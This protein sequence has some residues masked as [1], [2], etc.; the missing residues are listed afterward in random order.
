MNCVVSDSILTGLVQPVLGSFSIN[1]NELALKTQLRLDKKLKKIAEAFMKG[2][3][4]NQ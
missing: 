2:T 3:L 1:L 4:I